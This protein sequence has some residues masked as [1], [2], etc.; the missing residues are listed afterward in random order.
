VTRTPGV[1]GDAPFP[2]ADQLPIAVRAY[3][4]LAEPEP[5]RRWRMPPTPSDWVLIFDT[6]TTTDPSQRLRFGSF[7]WRRGS[8]LDRA[9]LFYAPDLSERDRAVLASYAKAHGLELMTVAEFIE[10]IFYKLAYEFR[11]TIVGFNLPFDISRLAIGHSAARRRPMRGGFSFQLSPY[12]WRPRVQVKH[13]SRRAALSRFAA[14]PRQRSSRSGRKHDRVPVRRGFFVDVKTVGAAMTSRSDTLG[15]LAEFLKVP[16]RKMV[17]DEHGSRLTREYIAYAVNDTQVTWECCAELAQRYAR[18]ALLRTPISRI[19]SEAG[20]GKAYLIEMGIRPWRLVQPDFPAWLTEVIM[21]TYYGGRSEVHLRRTTAQIAY[22]DFLSM[23][24][25]VCTLMGLWRW[26]I[27]KGIDWRDT[28]EETRAFLEGTAVDDWRRQPSWR[29]LTTLVQIAADDD[30]LPARAQYGGEAQYTIGLNHLTSERPGWY[31]LADCINAKLL[32]GKCPKIIRAISFEPQGIQDGLRAIA[33]GGNPEFVI[34]PRNGDFYKSLIEQRAQVKAQ[35]KAC[36]PEDREVLDS[37][38]YAL[39]ILANA[40]SYGIFVE[41]NVEDLPKPNVGLRYAGESSDPRRIAISRFEAPGRYF[42]PLLAT[43]IT[44]G[45]RLMLGLAERLAIDNGLDWAFCD[46][47]SMAFAKPAGMTDAQFGCRVRRIQDWFQSLNPYDGTGDL[48]KME[49]ANYAVRDGKI[50]SEL[51]PLFIWAISSKR[52]ALFNLDTAGGP[53]LR[54]ASA[55]GLGHLLAPYDESAASQSI[56][57]PIILLKDIGVDRWQ[58]DVWHRIVSAALGG[59]TNQPRLADLPGFNKPAASRY[60]STTPDLLAWFDHHNEGREYG[61]QVKPFNFLTAYQASVFSWSDGEEAEGPERPSKRSR[62]GGDFPRPIA[63]YAR[64]PSR[65]AK[66]CFDR[67]T[68]DPIATD[69]LKTYAEALAQ[70]HLHPEAKFL[71]GDFLDS[72]PT[73]RRHIRVTAV[74]AIGK[75]ANRWEEQFHLG[76][77]P[78]AQIEYGMTEDDIAG[79]RARVCAG[80][81][82]Y[83]Q[84]RLA[85]AAGVSRE[86]L[87]LFIAGEHLMPK[88]VGRLLG[89]ISALATSAGHQVP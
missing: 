5:V 33:I 61:D 83:G 81:H 6:E 39:K 29:H 38:Q 55:H 60:G 75:E 17:T 26:V 30:V 22:C 40:T 62:K 42:H 57:S 43:F 52:Y 85:A 44:G 10:E 36:V 4:P 31:T 45:A 79:V 1:S 82:A 14:P 8:K 78:E 87:R 18:H 88:T 50:T 13:L 89:A 34:D 65:A 37:L 16:S 47:D 15:S 74:R 72:G 70:Y 66:E 46:T 35:L 71:N 77:D 68:G 59:H 2:L 86:R 41:L 76:Y 11:A 80:A 7:Q 32:G 9:G 58:Y 24:P 54:K 56:P 27:A 20:V 19:K 73:E 49:D 3:V 23:Y 48:L 12:P 64:D 51:H 53:V 28:T 21:Q 69:R 67:L 63:P 84:R 25:T